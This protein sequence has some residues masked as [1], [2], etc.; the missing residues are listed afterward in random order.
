MGMP[1]RPQ[2][3]G[4][5]RSAWMSKSIVRLALVQSVRWTFPPVSFHTSQESTVPNRSSPA[6]A[7]ARAPSTWS[8]IQL[9]LVAEK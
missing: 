7:R 8:R 3:W 9:S 6:S 2:I 5:Q 1:R 4:S